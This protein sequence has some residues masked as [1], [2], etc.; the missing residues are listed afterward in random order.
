MDRAPFRG[1][2]QNLREEIPFERRFTS[3]ISPRAVHHTLVASVDNDIKQQFRYWNPSEHLVGQDHSD[4]S[5]GFESRTKFKR[6][7]EP[8]ISAEN[9]AESSSSTCFRPQRQDNAALLDDRIVHVED[10]LATDIQDMMETAWQQ[11]GLPRP[12]VWTEQRQIV[13]DGSRLTSHDD[14]P[15]YASLPPPYTPGCEPY[16]PAHNPLVI[17]RI[18]AQQ[19]MLAILASMPA[20]RLDVLPPELA[21]VARKSNRNYE[22]QISLAQQEASRTRYM[23]YE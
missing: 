20:E 2:T 23:R 10:G 16:H 3:A 6:L 18:M 21:D 14:P 4:G 22:K 5:K 9:Q 15:S 8:A 12:N 13:K 17:E 1:D 19:E 7:P 11:I